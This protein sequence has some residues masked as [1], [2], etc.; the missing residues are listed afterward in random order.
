MLIRV[1]LTGNVARTWEASQKRR[2]QTLETASPTCLCNYLLICLPQASMARCIFT[3]CVGLHP[4][5]EDIDGVA[6]WLRGKEF[7]K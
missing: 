2:A 5:L 1:E 7:A 6:I 3:C 4:G